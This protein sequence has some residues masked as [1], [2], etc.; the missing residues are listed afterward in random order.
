MS[1]T[2]KKEEETTTK[3]S[4]DKRNTSRANRGMDLEEIV[5]NQ[6]KEYRKEGKAYMFKLPTDWQVLRRG[7]FIISA[8]PKAK[9]LTD[10]FGTL[11]TGEAIAIEV[12]NT[13]NKTSFPLGNIKEHQFTF[14]EEWSKHTRHSYYLIRFKEH[15]EIY[16]VHSSK[17][18]EFRD[19]E[20]R[21]SIPYKWFGENAELLNGA[22]FLEKILDK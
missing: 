14:L 8:F 22:D 5:G 1:N 19:S 9:S 11:N 20:T 16:L 3:T 12:K 2:I 13:N 15:D 17:V 21:K 10:F 4:V 18:Q 6:C 7:K